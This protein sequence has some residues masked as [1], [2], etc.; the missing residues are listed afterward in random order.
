MDIMDMVLGAKTSNRFPHF[1]PGIFTITIDKLTSRS[2]Q[3]D[4]KVGVFVL[5]ATVES[6]VATNGS[7]PDA[8]TNGSHVSQVWTTNNAYAGK[9]INDLVVGVYRCIAAANGMNPNSLS[10]AELDKDRF[11]ALLGPEGLAVGVRISCEVL[12]KEK[13]KKA[14]EFYNVF[15]WAVPKSA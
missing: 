5:E 9:N 8:F 15:T 13:V 6:F 3:M 12:P 11:N 1:V 7:D 4:A 14:G 2:S 10:G